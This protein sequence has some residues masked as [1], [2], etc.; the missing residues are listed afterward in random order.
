MDKINSSSSDDDITDTDTKPIK[1]IVKKIKRKKKPTIL[2]SIIG[3]KNKALIDE[4]TREKAK[5]PEVKA[6]H[7]DAYGYPGKRGQMDVLYLPNDNGFKYLLV[8]V[9]NYTKKTDAIPLRFRTAEAVRKAI[10]KIY[11]ENKVL[12]PPKILQVD[13]GSEFKKGLDEYLKPKGIHLRRAGV[14]RHSQQ[15][16]V[17]ARNKAIGSLI[18][19]SQLVK[20]LETDK[21]S[22]QWLKLLPD[23]LK[24][25]NENAKP[26]KMKQT[27]EVPCKVDGDCDLYEVND[28]VRYKL[29]YP[30][31]Y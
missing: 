21:V 10:D 2:G 9:D 22:K 13:A 29:D 5:E 7:N 30:V 14:A 19:K 27:G 18:M 20:E 24:K 16:N 31:N 12:K 8:A 26:K 4:L 28:M 23:I 15:A 11:Y 3:E 6:T 25:L 1:K 17:E